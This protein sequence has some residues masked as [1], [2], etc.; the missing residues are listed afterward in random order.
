MHMTD[1]LVL[2]GCSSLPVHMLDP[3]GT[4][5]TDLPVLAGCFDLHMLNLHGT[6][7][8]DVLALV[9]CS[10]LHTLD[11]E[12]C[13]LITPGQSKS[14]TRCST[15]GCLIRFYAAVFFLQFLFL[16]DLLRRPRCHVDCK[17]HIDR[18]CEAEKRRYSWDA[19]PSPL[20]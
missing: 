13:S 9:G 10:G 17:A 3:C 5:V 12:V 20:V 2:V 19:Q 11:L 15:S 18:I 4:G 7:V 6:P 14:N 8:I 16:A 1:M